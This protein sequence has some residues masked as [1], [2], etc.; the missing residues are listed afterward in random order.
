MSRLQTH[1]PLGSA[2]HS[3]AIGGGRIMVAPIFEAETGNRVDVKLV[4]GEEGMEALRRKLFR[5]VC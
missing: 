5:W 2:A 3:V 4:Q 1:G